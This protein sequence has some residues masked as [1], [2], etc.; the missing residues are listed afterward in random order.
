MTTR[1]K[2]EE[3]SRLVHWCSIIAEN[4]NY[5]GKCSQCEIGCREKERENLED[6]E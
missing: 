3:Y 4:C 1:P 5:G 2:N 6:D